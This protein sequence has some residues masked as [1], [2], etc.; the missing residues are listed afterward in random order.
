MKANRFAIRMDSRT[1]FG[2]FLVSS[3]L[4]AGNAWADPR[5]GIPTQLA[6]PPPP[7]VELRPADPV[8]AVDIP[9]P[10][11]KAPPPPKKC[12][13]HRAES[14]TF[15]QAQGFS[16]SSLV[17]QA[18]GTTVFAQGV[19][20]FIPGQLLQSISLAEICE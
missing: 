4:L 2:V 19:N 6:L 17:V 16:L 9:T 12:V 5:R 10:T 8:T 15:V 3:M 1:L 14:S 20:S 11:E 18:C 7:R 13:W